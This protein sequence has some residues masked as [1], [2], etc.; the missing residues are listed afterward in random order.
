M[1]RALLLL[2]SPL[3]STPLN[4]CMRRHLLIKKHVNSVKPESVF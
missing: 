4:I 3:M 2:N 1:L